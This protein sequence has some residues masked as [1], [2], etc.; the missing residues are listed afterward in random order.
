M[1]VSQPAGRSDRGWIS[2][3]ALSVLEGL[4]QRKT[5]T[6]IHCWNGIVFARAA[7]RLLRLYARFG[8]NCREPEREARKWDRAPAR[9]LH[10]ILEAAFFFF[11]FF[12]CTRKAARKIA[13]RR[14]EDIRAVEVGRADAQ[15]GSRS[16]SSG[17]FAEEAW[18]VLK[19]D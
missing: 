14:T 13:P 18:H 17:R 3:L 15:A 1:D 2:P 9:H 12:F 7:R 4:R 5:G 11:F 19:S 6:N 16:T 10:R 8:K